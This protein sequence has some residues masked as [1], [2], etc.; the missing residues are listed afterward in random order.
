[1]QGASQKFALTGA[2]AGVDSAWEQKKLEATAFPPPNMISI[3][4]ISS[5]L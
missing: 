1:M 2:M 4:F 5:K 3:P